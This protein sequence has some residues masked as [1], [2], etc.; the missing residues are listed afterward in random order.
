MKKCSLMAVAVVFLLSGCLLR[1]EASK[2]NE[3][4]QKNEMAQIG[5]IVTL[6][7]IQGDIKQS[8]LSAMF[9]VNNPQNSFKVVIK[10]L[11]E[12]K[13]PGKI[14]CKVQV[15]KATGSNFNAASS[16]VVSLGK[17]F[18]GAALQATYVEIPEDSNHRYFK[19][20]DSTIPSNVYQLKIEGGNYSKAFGEIFS[21]PEYLSG[22]ISGDALTDAEI[23][24][25][26]DIHN[27][28]N[29]SL[30]WNRETVKNSNT[31]DM[32]EVQSGAEG[33]VTVMRCFS[34]EKDFEQGDGKIRL[35]IDK[36][37]I[38][39][40]PKNDKA[41]LMVSR[42]HVHNSDRADIELQ[43]IRTQGFKLKIKE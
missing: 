15:K 35:T 4:N 11:T 9:A 34:L 6:Q 13:P 8:S 5:G 27:T 32:I 31:I 40:L 7:D 37:F 2:N 14:N 10:Q 26:S 38:S 41:V 3:S 18:F 43:G 42:V 19:K 33:D 25:N 22:L 24:V 30:S 12:A 1:Q 20:F 36:S 29:L 28:Q 17:V 39:Q 16:K 21:M 23:P